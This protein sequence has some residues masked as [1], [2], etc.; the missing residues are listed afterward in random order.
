MPVHLTCPACGT[1]TTKPP[2][3]AH[4]VYC[5]MRCAK[6]KPREPLEIDETGTA[7]IPLRARDGSVRAYALI[8][9]ADAEWA[10][11]W[12]WSL[13]SD[14][15]AVRTEYAGK[16]KSVRLFRL[17]RE[18]LGLMRGVATDGDH[19]DRNRLNNRRANLRATPKGGNAQNKS[20]HAGSSSQY[21]GV[22]WNKN[23]RKWQ[24]TVSEN[25]KV[26]YLGSYASEEEAAEVARAARERLMPYA[27]N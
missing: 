7:R 19:W 17:H 1:V 24:A 6:L 25:G 23:A 12:R 13:D 4:Q 3:K 14:G 18:L 5:S 21:R 11:Q 16:G 20:S 9:A 26:K 8:D 15:Y 2:S 27:T 10:A 22:S